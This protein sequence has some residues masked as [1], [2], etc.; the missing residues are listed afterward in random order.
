MDLNKYITFIFYLN[1]KWIHKIK[2][3]NGS[4]DN[5]FNKLEETTKKLIEI[6]DSLKN[7]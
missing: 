7:C 4:T 6:G 3:C 5:Y 1:S 2:V